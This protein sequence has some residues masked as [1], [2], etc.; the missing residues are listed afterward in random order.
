[1]LSY[2][3]KR[4]ALAVPTVAIV[5]V[6]V[7]GMMR[8]IPGDP[9]TL[10]LGDINDPALLA[11]VRHQLGLDRS[12][13]EQFVLWLSHLLR[14]DLGMSIVRHQPVT[15]LIASTFPVTAQIVLAATLLASL[16]AIPAGLVAAW[17]QNR[18]ADPAIV[19]TGILLV[20]LPSFWVGILLMWVFGV[21]LHWLPTFGYESFGEAGW[22]T[23]RYLV[24]PVVAVAL[25]EIAVLMRI[26]RASSLEVLR[27]EY[28]A[29]AR[30]KGLSE[31]RVLMRHALPN[32]FG[33]ALTVVGLVLGH[34]LAGG[35]VIE[36]VF[37]LPGMGRLLV[38]SIYARDYPVVQGCLLV[39][40][41]VYVFVN[42]IVD[43]LH[44]L[45]DPRMKI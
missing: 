43:L 7:F 30:A 4:I 16:I 36:T 2:L 29:H 28:I 26:M 41:L 38:E 45:F 18:R 27:L 37:T 24:L 9:A 17:S 19:F 34:L 40:A 1:M 31:S 10:M 33:P 22:G 15:E 44:P 21:R 13:P 8:A 39:I 25:G 14:G 12:V 3:F 32:A 6:L 5:T 11:Q 23:L 42:L 35:A 20:S